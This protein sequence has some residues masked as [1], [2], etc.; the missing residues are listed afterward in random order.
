M[1]DIKQAAKWMQ[2]RKRVRRPG[3]GSDY[4]WERGRGIYHGTED[5]GEAMPFTSA[6]ILADDW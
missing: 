2:E 3:D 5:D 4:V 1:A 6:D